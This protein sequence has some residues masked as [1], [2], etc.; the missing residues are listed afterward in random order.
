M[1]Y[2]SLCNKAYPW[3]TQRSKVKKVTS[4]MTFSRELIQL[5]ILIR[6]QDGWLKSANTASVLCLPLFVAMLFLGK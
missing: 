5:E 4:F 6:T 3:T 2:R 1:T